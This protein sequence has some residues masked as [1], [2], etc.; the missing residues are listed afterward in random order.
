MDYVQKR[1]EI[2]EIIRFNYF[3]EFILV[4]IV[5]NVEFVQVQML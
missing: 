2:K 1:A 5:V 3:Q 4:L